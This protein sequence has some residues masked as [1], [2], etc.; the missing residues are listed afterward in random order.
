MDEDSDAE[1][2]SSSGLTENQTLEEH[3]VRTAV[4]LSLLEDLVGATRAT[5]S[6]KEALQRRALD[7]DK[8]LLQLL[9]AEC[10]EGEERGMKALE[11]VGLLRDRSG[12]M[13][14]AAAKIA[15]RFGRDV[16]RGKIEELAERRL[17]GLDADDDEE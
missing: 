8:A 2:P 10:R 1:G 3:F 17:V 14:D 7:V 4:H 11:I 13:L 6:Q 16:L 5:S 9:A 15:S 12:R